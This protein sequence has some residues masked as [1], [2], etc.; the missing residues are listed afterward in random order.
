M[1]WSHFDKDAGRMDRNF[2]KKTIQHGCFPKNNAKF[3][4]QHF[5]QNTFG[6]CF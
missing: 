2:I 6:G 5:L 3:L 4:K 1:Y